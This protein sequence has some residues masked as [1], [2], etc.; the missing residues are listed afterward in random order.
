MEIQAELNNMQESMEKSIEYFEGQLAKVRTGRAS[1]SLLDGIQADA[2]G[3]RQ[4]LNAV[5]TVNVPDARTIVVQPWDKSLI[6]EIEK[7]IRSADLGLNPQNDG[8]IIRIPVPPLTE[9]RRN[10]YVKVAKKYAEEA[11]IAVRNIRRDANDTFKKAEKDKDIS[12]DDKK[13]AEDQVQKLTDKYIERI[14][15]LATQKEKELLE[16]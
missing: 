1:Q 9:E 4:P 11:K 15:G 16:D 2:Y 14:D 13:G 6:T 7:A 12:E 5:A 10:E 3:Q 8:T